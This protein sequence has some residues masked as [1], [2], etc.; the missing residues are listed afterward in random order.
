MDRQ[1]S[2]EA[3]TSFEL[4]EVLQRTMVEIQTM[5]NKFTG[6]FMRKVSTDSV[7]MTPNPSTSIQLDE[8]NNHR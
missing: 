1:P 3:Q 7:D 2:N 4:Y 5:L 6:G 8:L